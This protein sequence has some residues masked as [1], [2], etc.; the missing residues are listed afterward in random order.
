[1][2]PR[3]L[4]LLAAASLT[5]FAAEEKSLFTGTGLKGWKTPH[6]TWQ[7]VKA[8]SLDPANAK[9]FRTEAGEG[10][11]LNSAAGHTGDLF[12]EAD[13]GDCELHVEFSVPKDS[14]S[15]VYLQGRYEVQILDSFGKKDEALNYGDCGGLYERPEKGVGFQGKAPSV[16][17]SKAPGEWQTFDIT[18]RAPR[19]DAAAKKTENAR[20]IKVVHNGK[21]IHENVEVDG[22]TRS[23]A[24]QDE[25]PL[26][27]L[28]L[29]GDH[30]PVAF[31]NLKLKA[32]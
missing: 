1:M 21:T 20:F 29:Q 5:A 31:R 19:F 16:N 14:N 32:L 13:H 3:I 18:F 11:L 4:L 15:G 2:S 9:A 22:P 8:V 28:K 6:G 23:A 12:T 26:G 7:T 25:K 27:P 17:A 30:G 24:F 10:V